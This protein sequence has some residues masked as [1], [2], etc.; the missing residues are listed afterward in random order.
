MHDVGAVLFP[1][2]RLDPGMARSVPKNATRR[3]DT[4]AI[5]SGRRTTGTIGTAGAAAA[6]AS[7]TRSQPEATSARASHEVGPEQATRSG[8]RPRSPV[9]TGRDDEHAPPGEHRRDRGPAAVEED[10]LRLERRGRASALVHVRD[11]DG[12]GETAPAAPAAD[13]RD[14]GQRGRLE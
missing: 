10:E 8:S 3:P 12:A 13:R 14:A 5:G 4:D 9:L 11:P 7:R 6:S 1:E 2:M